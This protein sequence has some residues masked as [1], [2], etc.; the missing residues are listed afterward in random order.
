MAQLT[1]VVDLGRQCNH[2]SYPDGLAG[3]PVYYRGCNHCGL[4]FTDFFDRFTPDQ[5]QE[6]IYNDDYARIDPEYTGFRAGRSVPI[7][8]AATRRWFL[9]GDIGCEFGGGRGT[10]ADLLTQDGLP[11]ES[12]DP[13]G[14]Q[15][16]TK[17]PGSYS[18]VT[19]FEVLE[20]VPDPLA[21]FDKI[22]GLLTT[23][24]SLCLISTMTND[25]LASSGAL[26]NWW[27]AAP[28]NGHITLYAQKTLKMLADRHKLDYRKI[29]RSVHLFGHGLDLSA[30]SRRVLA[31][32][33]RQRLHL[34]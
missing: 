25:G 23:S 13:F 20:H 6:C 16:L 8:R 27:Y 15:A 31:A 21:V 2:T 30:I 22:A 9:P 11:F 4:V 14:K 17:D 33:I 7:V 29:T 18:I 24:R 19:A 10:L 12:F 26:M 34:A 3:I 1:D 32:K 28:R 5:W